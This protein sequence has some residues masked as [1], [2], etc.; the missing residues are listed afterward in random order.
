MEIQKLKRKRSKYYNNEKLEDFERLMNRD[1]SNDIIQ[2]N[3]FQ[4][5]KSL[6]DSIMFNFLNQKVKDLFSDYLDKMDKES[7]RYFLEGNSKII[8]IRKMF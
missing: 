1:K 6:Y 2:S 5:N 3:F 7:G 8:E 4:Q